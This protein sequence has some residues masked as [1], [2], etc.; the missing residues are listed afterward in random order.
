MRLVLTACMFIGLIIGAAGNWGDWIEIIGSSP[1]S[2]HT[3]D[4]TIF[5]SDSTGVTIQ[6]MVYGYMQYDT[7]I[8]SKD[9]EQINIPD[10][11]L[12]DCRDDTTVIGK[13]QIPYIKLLIAVPDSATMSYDIETSSYSV[14]KDKLLY[15]IPRIEFYI[16]TITGAIGSREVYAYDTTFYENTDTLCPGILYEVVGDGHW[17]DQRILEVHLF[18]LQY[19]PQQNIVLFYH[20]LDLKISY[21]GTVVENTKGL[22]PFE[23]I[24]RD[25]LVNYPGVALQQPQNPDPSVHYYT[26]LDT[27]NI[28]DYIIVTHEKFLDDETISGYI[29]SFAQWRVDHNKF[30]VGI[31]KMSDVYDEF[32]GGSG[33]SAKAL[34]DFL[35]YA[36]DFWNSPSNADT[37]F[38]YCLFIGDWEYVPI[39]T[40][41][42]DEGDTVPGT[43]TTIWLNAYEG[44]FR[45]IDSTEINP[46]SSFEDI[47]LG[48]WPVDSTELPTIV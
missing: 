28:A 1:D 27:N 24:G 47:M 22:G 38:A 36:Y 23:D 39:E 13:P 16:D 32:L 45:D 4:I 41:Y 6:T 34:R 48:R 42:V 40:C 11:Y 35:V 33:D 12:L 3:P 5:H 37:H 2:P 17:R 20:G 29:D 30:D 19:A 46:N 18:P 21:S 44:Y 15:P 43:Q 10:G 9:F 31:V 8:D 25:I 26:N 14:L 7:T